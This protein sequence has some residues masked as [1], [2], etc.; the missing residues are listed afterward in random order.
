MSRTSNLTCRLNQNSARVDQRTCGS[1]FTNFRHTLKPVANVLLDMDNQLLLDMDQS[2]LQTR[3]VAP[4]RKD[5]QAH[6]DLLETMANQERTP[7]QET[8]ELKARTDKSSSVLSHQRNHVSSAHLEFQELSVNQGQR[9][10]QG[11]KES[12]QTR[13]MTERRANRAC[14]DLKEFP[15]QLELQEPPDQKVNQVESFKSTDPLGQ[16][17]NVD[18][19]EALDQKVP[20][21]AT[22]KLG[23]KE[24]LDLSETKATLDLK[25]IPDNQDQ[26]VYKEN[27]VKRA[28]ATTAQP[29]EPH[30]VIRR[31]LPGMV[32]VFHLDHPAPLLFFIHLIYSHS[33]S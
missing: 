32:P 10:P 6:P 23:L 19:P 4:V 14:Q 11:Q 9:D 31:C 25:E 29:H 3:R 33:D 1:K 17:E 15:D 28:L 24:K 13:P 8:M 20:Q 21:V 16:L 30:Q 5:P 7:I 18:H 2:S 12:Q 27:L 22:G 26:P